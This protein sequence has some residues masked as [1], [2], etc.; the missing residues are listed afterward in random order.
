MSVTSTLAQ[1]LPTGKT[2]REV[3]HWVNGQTLTGTSGRFG[4]VFNPASGEVQAR[5]ALATPAEVDT[6]VAAASAAFPEWS[7]QPPLRRARVLFRF[8]EI[9]E[10]RLDEVAALLTSEHGKSS[11]MQ[12]AKRHADSKSWSLQPASRRCSR[13]SSPSRWA[14]ESIAGPCASRSESSQESRRSTSQQWCQCGCSQSLSHA[15]T[16]SSSSRVSAT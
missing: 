16:H 11:P 8:R 7:E 1:P 9:F 2:L 6:A 3:H 4:D 13:V 10:R 12:E 5:V 14:R 15:G